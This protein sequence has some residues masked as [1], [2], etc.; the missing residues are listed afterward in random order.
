MAPLLKEFSAATDHISG[1]GLFVFNKPYNP[2]AI[3]DLAVKH[4]ASQKCCLVCW[5]PCWKNWTALFALKVRFAEG[6][7]VALV[8]STASQAWIGL[9]LL[10]INPYFPVSVP[11]KPVSQFCLF[12]TFLWS[13]FFKC[14]LLARVV[15]LQNSSLELSPVRRGCIMSLVHIMSTRHCERTASISHTVDSKIHFEHLIDELTWTFPVTEI[16][17][18]GLLPIVF[19]SNVGSVLENNLLTCGATW[20]KP[21]PWWRNLQEEVQTL[22]DWSCF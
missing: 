20:L 1:G 21:S 6:E 18:R 19:W 12:L 22:F 3:R 16:V 17:F 14:V 9:P 4:S 8:W 11:C 15:I 7:A 2:S 13:F 5:L 10:S